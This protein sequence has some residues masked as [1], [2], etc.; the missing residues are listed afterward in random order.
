[1]SEAPAPPTP[2]APA[3]VTRFAPSPTGEL[4]V[5][6]ARTALFAWAY[7]RRH[8]D[9]GGRFLL[10]FEDTDQK[11][12]SKQAEANI[13]RDLHWLGLYADNE[14]S[15][16][17]PDRQIPRQS[18]R[19]DLYQAALKKLADAGHTYEDDGAIRF[20]M[21]RDIA[22]DDAVYGHIVTKADDLEDFVIRKADG[23]P[24][25]H[26]AVVVDDIDMA[27]TH[28]IRGQE[29]LT[30]T[31]KHA[32]LYDALGQPRPVWCHTPSIMNPDGSKMSKR[33]KAK[34]ARHA[35]SRADAE[36]IKTLV[37]G[38]P[39]EFA[40]FQAKKNDSLSVAVAVAE[41]LG[42]TL[43]EIN[44][45]DFRN[46]GYLPEVLLN[47]LALLGWNP[48]NDL[49]RFDLDYL[50]RHFDFDRIGRSN[51]KFDR[52]KLAAFQQDTFLQM[53][54]AE[55][56]KTLRPFFAE[57]YPAETQTLGEHFDL[58][59]A[60]YRERSKTLRD[61]ADQGRFFFEAPTQYN[62]KA[63]K[64][65]LTKNDG[66]GLAA[67]GKLRGVLAD[68]KPWEASAIHARIDELWQQLGLP[69]MGGVAQPLRVALTGHAVSPEIGPTLQIL[70]RDETLARIDRCLAEVSP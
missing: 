52:E 5:G 15:D 57:Y 6:G 39:D 32:A 44:V 22:F 51:S 2:P 55:W 40:A 64:K 56:A 43:P 19:L 14:P 42:V 33:D 59:A 12:S 65:N 46:S 31:A 11:R 54:D 10:R 23:F 16:A 70:G 50:A 63:V 49:E 1:M 20:R 18:E 67:L 24:T 34:A 37:V 29:H 17:D 62:A 48:G 41:A 7:A 26:L 58:F 36:I 3:V 45:A 53:S 60:A 9:A 38:D 28:V 61:P 30:N 8:A 35:L 47:Y 27:V 13:L 69:H 25:F 68:F 21:D 4:H 66:E